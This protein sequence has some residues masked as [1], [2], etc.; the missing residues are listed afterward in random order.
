VGGTNWG[1]NGANGFTPAEMDWVGENLEQGRNNV[2]ANLARRETKKLD[3]LRTKLKLSPEEFAALS[4]EQ[5]AKKIK[6]KGL[7]DGPEGN[8]AWGTSRDTF[9]QKL[10]GVFTDGV[11]NIANFGDGKSFSS[12]TMLVDADGNIHPRTCFVAG[13]HVTVEL[14]TSGA[15]EKAGNWFKKIEEIKE[16]DLVLSLNENSRVKSYNKVTQ[17][18]KHFVTLLFV[19]NLSTGSQIEATWNHPFYVQDDETGLT[20]GKWVETKVSAQLTQIN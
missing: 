10:G 14:N 17:L 1:T 4:P 3:E 5:L 13:T 20:T 7:K 2:D 6:E 18:F 8:K 11:S 12:D 15:F 16:G 9:L 19:L